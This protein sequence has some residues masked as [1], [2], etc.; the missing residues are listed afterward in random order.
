MKRNDHASAAKILNTFR[1]GKMQH[2]SIATG[3]AGGMLLAGIGLSA[4]SASAIDAGMYL[5]QQMQ[6]N[7]RPVFGITGPL[8]A[9]APASPPQYRTAAQSAS[10]QVALAPGLTAAYLTRQAANGADMFA[11][12]PNAANPTHVIFCIESGREV[13]GTLPSGITKYNP[14]VQRIGI[15][16]SVETILRGLNGCDGIRLTPWGTILATE[17]ESDGGAYEIIDPLGTTNYTVQTRATGSIIDAGGIADA[18]R[19]AKRAALPVIAW[20]GFVILPSGV[21][22]GGDELRPGTGKPDADGGSLFK[23]IPATLSSGLT[24]ISNLSQSPLVS[25]SVHAL[26]VSCLDNVQQAGQGCET[27]NAAWIPVRAAMAR[28][29]AD[30]LGATGYY[31]PEDMERDPVY[32]DTAHPQAIR[33][34]WTNT[35]NEG[36]LSYGEVLCAVDEN[37][38]IASPV[39]RTV[40]VSRFLEGDKDFNSFDNLAFQPGSGI[41]YVVEDHNNG[42]VFACLPDGADRDLASDGCMKVLSVKDTGAEPT[43]FGFTADGKSAVLSIQHSNDTGLPLSDGYASDDILIISGFEP[44]AH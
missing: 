6:S 33:F 38:A 20:E 14:S 22:I 12:W 11:F 8:A 32:A 5:Q 30:S 26:Q 15:N 34:C 27:G 16:G 43:G 1:R 35:Q 7:S 9:S 31:R 13:I 36:A 39:Q 2:R 21:V 3:L 23:F 42:D 24:S 28:A 29:D 17:E 25:G 10:D 37:P 44:P 41:L 4:R 40:S 19:I 18:A